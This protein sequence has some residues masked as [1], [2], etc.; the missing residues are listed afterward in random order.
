MKMA[1]GHVTIIRSPMPMGDEP[2]IQARTDPA[3]ST[4]LV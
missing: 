1:E 4:V 2:N 3:P